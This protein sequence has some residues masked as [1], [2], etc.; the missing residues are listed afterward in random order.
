MRKII[1]PWKRIPE[2]NCFGCSENN[3]DG[4]KMKFEEE[5]GQLVCHWH[6]QK[7]F[8]G[9]VNVLHGGIQCTLMDEMAA[10]VI[11]HDLKVSGMTTKLETKFLKPLH[12]DDLVLTIRG[13]LRKAVHRLAQVDVSIENS[14]GEVCAQALATYYTFTP[15]ESV[16]NFYYQDFTYEE[17]NNK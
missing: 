6:P 3:A 10:W 11:L 5:D 9:W 4:L 13:K 1:N 12:T 14:K 2:F 16:K 15:E 17:E 7:Q 8:Q